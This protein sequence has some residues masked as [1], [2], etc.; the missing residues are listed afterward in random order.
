MSRNS[1]PLFDESMPAG[2][3][4]PHP[5]N[6]SQRTSRWVIPLAALFG[7]VTLA[8]LGVLIV[9]LAAVMNTNTI[10]LV[11]DGE[12]YP[13]T[14]HAQTVAEFLQEINFDTNSGDQIA[15]RLD[16]PIQANLVI[17]VRRARSV[18]VVVNGNSQLLWTPLTNPAELLASAGVLLA[19]GDRVTLDGTYADPMDLA[20][21]PVPVSQIVVQHM[22]SFT[23]TIDDDPPRTLSTA[24][25][26]IGEAL[27][28]AGISIY[29]ADS[30]SV[31][32]NTPVQANLNVV[33]RRASPVTVIADGQVFHP[34]ARGET[35]AEALAEAG[36]TLAGL[37]YSIPAPDS[38]LIPGMSIRVIRVREELETQ[39]QD[40][41][42]ESVYQADP[43]LELDQRRV[44]TAGQ[45][46]IHRTQIRVRY[47]NN[48]AISR[49]V[50]SEGVAVEPVN[51]VI[52]YGTNIVLRSV[53]TPN[54]PMQYYRHFRMYAT[55]YHPVNGDNITATGAV[56]QR[57]IVGANPNILPYGTQIYVPDYGVGSV[58]DT[59][60]PRSSP[61]WIDLGYTEADYQSWHWYVDVYIL[62]PPPADITYMLPAWRPLSGRPDN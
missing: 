12:A 21:W 38:P 61:Y 17:E 44:I 15:P 37:D 8:L 45:N 42:Y 25:D 4:R 18:S 1:L 20:S 49:D 52:G 35:T 46:G 41:P 22:Q 24:R 16:T 5:P 28:E 50:E 9:T 43:T 11:I 53:D 34:R 36:I 10:T 26:T 40:I 19:P 6:P 31:D 39:D 62:A 23:V 54:G 30:V 56:L 7:S 29:L 48:I 55:S 33:I 27:Y 57:G 51:E 13:A 32:L 58:Q 59:G 14:T 2:P 47:E 3:T 60:G